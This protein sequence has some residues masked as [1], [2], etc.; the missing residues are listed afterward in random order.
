[1]NYSAKIKQL[2]RHNRQLCYMRWA[3]MFIRFSKDL[4][5][6]I[7]LESF[8]MKKLLVSIVRSKNCMFWEHFH[9]MNS[10]NIS[11]MAWTAW[12]F[13]TISEQQTC[14]CTWTF[15]QKIM[16]MWIIWTYILS[17]WTCKLVSLQMNNRNNRN[18]HNFPS[19]L[20][21]FPPQFYVRKCKDRWTFYI[22]GVLV[23]PPSR[24]CT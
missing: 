13:H 24:S 21:S 22:Y 11:S 4:Q 16:F 1:M 15:R 12:T 5:N 3:T 6:D 20:P 23:I 18:V 8:L 9:Y 19:F 7:Q 10:M 2:T 17:M 14:S